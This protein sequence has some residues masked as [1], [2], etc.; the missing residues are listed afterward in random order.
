MTL[1]FLKT[2]YLSRI[3]SVVTLSLKFCVETEINETSLGL[4][5]LYSNINMNFAKASPLPHIPYLGTEVSL[6]VFLNYFCEFQ[7]AIP[8]EK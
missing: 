4:L 1:E 6:P 5:T 3:R 2:G 7:G 8:D